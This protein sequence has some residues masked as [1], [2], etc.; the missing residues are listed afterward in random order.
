MARLYG[1]YPGWVASE[2]ELR[3][4]RPANGGAGVGRDAN[5][6]TVFGEGALPGELVRVELTQEKKRFARGSTI[7]ILEAAAGRVEP[8][9]STHRAGCGGCDMA[10]AS[11][12]TQRD[13]KAHVVRDAL[14][15]IGR[16]S[17]EE[18]EAA[19]RGFNEQPDQGWYRTT[20]RFAVTGNGLGY[21]RARSHS[22]VLPSECGVVH[23]RIEEVV[24]QGRFPKTAGPEVVVRTS[25]A[26]GETIVVVDGDST[27]VEVPGQATV[28]TRAELDAGASASFVE[29]AA[30]RTWQVSADS[31]FQAGAGVAS[32]LVE[33][34]REAAGDVAD[35]HLVDAYCGVGLFAGTVG[36]NAESVTAIEVSASSIRDAESNLD[37]QRADG[38]TVNIVASSVEE[39]SAT[40][41]DVVVADP[42]RSGL[43]AD[44][45]RALLACDASRFVLVSCDTGSFGR[46]AGLLRDAGYALESVRLV[47]AFRDT[48][49][50]ETVA[51]FRR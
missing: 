10:H 4:D 41:A 38:Q 11:I 39:W 13:I 5:G 1:P 3:I 50:V 42:A 26:T 23:P 47:D 45:V 25:A 20:A 21:R 51:S 30:G 34:V 22:V 27:G 12:E 7:E 6:R 33:A 35:A 48:S 16:F 19:W 28:L 43:G 46:D 36:A 31:F 17:T 2:I 49:H 29:E 40:K 32:S 37:Q 14:S 9:C 8:A 44:G 15:R 18:I 24:L